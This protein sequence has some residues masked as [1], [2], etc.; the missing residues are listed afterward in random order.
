MSARTLF[1]VVA[2]ASLSVFGGCSGV[3]HLGRVGDTDFYSVHSSNLD[4]PNIT[5]LVSEKNGEAKV[6]GVASGPGMFTGSVNA[7]L[8]A[9]GNVAGAALI[10]NGIKNIKGARTNVSNNS[11]VAVSG[12]AESN[13]EGGAGGNGGEGGGGGGRKNWTSYCRSQRKNF[14]Q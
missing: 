8:G 14:T 3:D 12:N 11:N 6:E 2:V 13:S 10:A 1:V 5:A 4:G 9:G 7:A